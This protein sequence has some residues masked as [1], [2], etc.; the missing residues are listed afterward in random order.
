MKKIVLILPYFGT[1]PN[2]FNLWLESVRNNPSIDFLIFSDNKDPFQSNRPKNIIFKHIEFRDFAALTQEKFPFKISLCSAYK[3]CDYKPAY[4]HIF[5]EEIK[6]YDFWGYCDCDL[7]FG[8][9]RKFLT[10]DILSAHDKILIRGHLT[11]VRNNQKMNELFMAKINGC[12]YYKDVYTD[13]KNRTFDEASG[14]TT[15]AEKEGSIKI[16]DEMLFDDINIAMKQF[17]ASQKWKRGD[18]NVWLGSVYRYDSKGLYK[19]RL[20]DNQ[21]MEEEILYVHFQKRDMTVDLTSEQISYGFLIV[22][23]RFIEI[24]KELSKLKYIYY[25]RFRFVYLKYWKIRYKNMVK[26]IKSRIK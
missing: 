5:N 13:S 3:L 4:G 26:K 19:I 16:Y 21:F 15:M 14:F 11:L 25:A 22:P 24:P 8:N 7:I 18:E 2:Y 12:P 10:E 1:F 20:K 6:E 17:M 9:I 23:N